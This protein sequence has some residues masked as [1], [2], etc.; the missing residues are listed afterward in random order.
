MELKSHDL[1]SIKR[2][3]EAYTPLGHELKVMNILFSGSLGFLRKTLNL[4]Q[5]WYFMSVR[6]PLL[7]VVKQLKTVYDVV[8]EDKINSNGI[9]AYFSKTEMTQWPS[10]KIL[11]SSYV[12]FDRKKKIGQTQIFCL[13]F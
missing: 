7:N 9:F 1:L 2:V 4:T 8:L 12:L 6:K 3:S 11:I 10:K 13:N 5:S